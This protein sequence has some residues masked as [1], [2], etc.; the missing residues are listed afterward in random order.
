MSYRLSFFA[1]KNALSIIRDG[2]LRP[3]QIKVMAGAAGGPKWLV[4]RG[5]D[6]VMFSSWF[7]GRTEP[8][9]LIGSSIGS[10][11]FAAVSRSN[12][13]S[14]INNLQAAYTNQIYETKPTAEEVT[15]E[16]MNILDHFLDETG[17]NEIVD[18]PY[19]RLSIT[20]VRCRW[21]VA[22]DNRV[23]LALGLAGAFLAN[24]LNRKWLRFFFERSLFYHPAIA[25]PFLN[26]EGFP[27]TRTPFGAKNLKPA[28]LASGSIPMV[29]S[30]TKDIP[31]AP[32]GIYRD[33]GIIDYHLDLPF[34]QDE[35]GL[36]LFPH[37]T[38]RII[39]GWFD[40]KLSWRRPHAS[41]MDNVLLI[42]PDRQFIEGL[43][44]K[45]IPDR[46]DFYLFKGKN[47]ERIHCWQ[48]VAKKSERLG[49]DFLDAVETGR[50]SELV[51]PLAF[52]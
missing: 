27:I 10:W 13:L 6:Q 41:N 48:T 17:V 5:L 4:L 46:N 12:P 39:P 31:D 20:T 28:L 52:S 49:Q 47:Q 51:R 7:K 36:V 16:S 45:K 34:L 30:G 32:S 21:P 18:H 2:G 25:P 38:D 1:G 3:E 19:L 26:M 35:E 37:Y 44:G 9:F 24:L 23:F 11:R 8:L 42:C 22:N 33:G 40:K 43:P 50:I 14:A 29:M 15:S